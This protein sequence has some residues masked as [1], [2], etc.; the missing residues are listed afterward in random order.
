M[1]MS[2]HAGAAMMPPP[3]I[4]KVSLTTDQ[5]ELISDTLAEFDPDNLTEADAATIVERFNEAGIQPT[6][7]LAQAMDEAGF[8]ARKIGDLAGIN[9][10]N[11]TDNSGRTGMTPQNNVSF[12]EEMLT[13]L[14]ELLDE[15]SNKVLT[16]EDKETILTTMQDKFSLSRG[17]SLFSIEA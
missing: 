5:V 10:E 14:E 17:D 16:N 3:N 6:R 2:I 7:E 1:S 4:Q 13:A 15:Y 9:P 12:T 8:N 11:S